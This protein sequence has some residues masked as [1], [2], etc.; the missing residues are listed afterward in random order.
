MRGALLDLFSE[1]FSDDVNA[2]IQRADDLL[3]AAEKAEDP[4][5]MEIASAFRLTSRAAADPEH[6]DTVAAAADLDRLSEHSLWPSGRSWRLLSQLTWAVRRGD[7]EAAE[8]SGRQVAADS[9][10]NG[11]PFFVQTAGP[12]LGGLKRGQIDQRL[13]GAAEAVRLIANAQEQVTYSL[14]FRSATIALHDAGHLATAARISG[15]VDSLEGGGHL[16]EVMTSE[17]DDVVDAVR[18]SLGADEFAHLARLGRRLDAGAA[19][20]L[21]VA[22]SAASRRSE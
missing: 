2:F 12:L 21:V 16:L 10:A 6:P 22:C 9:D 7:T 4:A 5:W 3:A 14:A 11:T 17:Y 19:A 18:R 20:E 13:D 15:F 1:L 8:E